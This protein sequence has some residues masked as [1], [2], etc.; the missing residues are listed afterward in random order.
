LTPRRVAPL[1]VLPWLA[2]DRTW[3]IAMA[4]SQTPAG[5]VRDASAVGPVDG[6][7]DAE[8]GARTARIELAMA[9]ARFRGADPRPLRALLES[10]DAARVIAQAGEGEE[11]LLAELDLAEVG[12]GLTNLDTDG[13]Y[14]RPDVFELRVDTRA[15]D[16]V[17]WR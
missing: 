11:T 1:P 13:H 12:E 10:G 4:R 16:G 5:E 7:T 2:G 14:A 3:L 9:L 15:K 6:P 8:V 17:A